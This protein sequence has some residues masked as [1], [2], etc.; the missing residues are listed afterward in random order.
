MHFVRNNTIEPNV[1]FGSDVIIGDNNVFKRGTIIEA[2]TI[3]GNGNVIFEKNWL[4]VAPASAYQRGDVVSKGLHIGDNNFFH[5]NNKISSGLDGPTVIGDNNT[6]L[7]DVYISHDN[8]V[9]NGV[10]FYPR[11]FSAGGVEFFDYASIG[12]GAAIQQGCKIGSYSMVGMNGVATK[13]VLPCMVCINNRY[14]RVNTKRVDSPGLQLI[15]G[16]LHRKSRFDPR[17]I[18]TLV[19][20][21][22]EP[23]F[24]TLF[25]PFLS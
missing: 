18:Q 14:E 23:K 11:V 22:L 17:H 9:H 5:V 6:F 7:S 2:G 3:I 21:H 13:D 12:A 15:A 10:T 25:D 19:Q 4:G 16:H 24:A 8:V 20:E 1:M